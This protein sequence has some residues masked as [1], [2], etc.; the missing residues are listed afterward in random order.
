VSFS[1]LIIM[2]NFDGCAQGKIPLEKV[3]CNSEYVGK[4]RIFRQGLHL[5]HR[6]PLAI[7]GPE[8]R[9]NYYN[10]QTCTCSASDKSNSCLIV[11]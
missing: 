9:A 1:Q 8:Y 7:F 6:S 3:L 2:A 11:R 10:P 5:E 4:M